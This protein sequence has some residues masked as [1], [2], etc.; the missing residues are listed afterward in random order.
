MSNFHN[1]ESPDQLT[2]LLSQ[3]LERVSLLSFWAPWAEPCKEMNKHVEEHAKQYSD[4]LFLSIDAEG[5]DEIA[6]SF[7]IEAVPSF[8]LLRGHTLLQRLTGADNN[9]LTS[10][11][12]QHG[13]RPIKALSHTDKAPAAPPAVPVKK[14][15]TPEELTARLTRLMNMDKAVLFMKGSPD[16]PQCGF[17]RRMVAL[18]REQN[19]PFTHFDIFTDESVR[20]GLKVH[21]KWPTFPQFIVNGEFVGGLDVV[22]EL[23]ENEEFEDIVKDIRVG[24]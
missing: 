13:R 11:L 23:V 16:K 10:A 4:V 17:S 6:D 14:V 15:E 8:L 12:A 21:N 22:K 9:A 18:L 5:Q 20:Q 3:D 2:E 1:V 7:E 19:V 24:T